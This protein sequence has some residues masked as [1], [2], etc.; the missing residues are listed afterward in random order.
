ML[1]LNYYEC[2]QSIDYKGLIDK[3]VQNLKLHLVD[4]KVIEDTFEYVFKLFVAALASNNLND[5]E[6]ELFLT[7]VRPIMF[8]ALLVN[9]MLSITDTEIPLEI[10]HQKVN[11]LV[12][13]TMD[14][15]LGAN[16]CVLLS[17]VKRDNITRL[18]VDVELSSKFTSFLDEYSTNQNQSKRISLN[19]LNGIIAISLLLQKNRSAKESTLKL[20]KLS[21][22]F[23]A[24]NKSNTELVDRYKGTI[25]KFLA[26]AIITITL[27]HKILDHMPT[28]QEIDCIKKGIKVELRQ[29][30]NKAKGI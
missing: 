17:K 27:Q 16:L 1:G 21:E 11:S 26:K 7:N 5:S 10:N 15:A 22:Q 13:G 29:M 24:S 28:T 19:L 2:S 18:F 3:A 14:D 6:E 9:N 30:I 12:D 4:I 23:A 20:L 25:T 8:D